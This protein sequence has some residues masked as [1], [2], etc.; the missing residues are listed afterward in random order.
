MMKK[1]SI[2]EKKEAPMTIE[3]EGFQLSEMEKLDLFEH[4]MK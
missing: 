3:A 2:F 1:K 4:N